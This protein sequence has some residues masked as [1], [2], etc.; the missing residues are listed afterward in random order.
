VKY[1]TVLTRIIE[2]YDAKSSQDLA[3]STFAD[4]TADRLRLDDA[5]LEE[6]FGD[7]ADGKEALTHLEVSTATSSHLHCSHLI[8]TRTTSSTT[9]FM[10]LSSRP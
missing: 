1:G 2:Y 4:A 3:N 9:W 10:P 8:T 5:V 6:V 7:D